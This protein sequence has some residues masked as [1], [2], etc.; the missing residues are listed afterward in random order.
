MLNYGPLKLIPL[1]SL[2]FLLFSLFLVIP[3]VHASSS[4]SLAT[5]S[6]SS[7]ATDSFW[8]TGAPMSTARAEIAGA[9]LNGKIY[10]VGGFD[11]TGRS[12]TSV[13]VYDPSADKWTTGINTTTGAAAPLP[14][15]LDHTAAA[16]Y[17][18]KLYVVGGDI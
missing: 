11:E 7:L 4:S 15:P 6:S 13:E 17:N 8:T 10:I 12:S 18:G 2:F 9:V 5:D 16:S 3:S 14:E 1:T